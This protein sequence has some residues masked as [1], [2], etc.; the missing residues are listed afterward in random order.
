MLI[1]TESQIADT[2]IFQ[3]TMIRIVRKPTIKRQLNIS[4]APISSLKISA[5][6][7]YHDLSTAVVEDWKKTTVKSFSNFGLSH[8]T[9]AGMQC[10][11]FSNGN[12][13]N[14]TES[15]SRSSGS[16]SSDSKPLSTSK[17][18]NQDAL[19]DPAIQTEIL[20]K[21]TSLH[22][23]IMP[24]NEK[25]RGPLAK[26]SD[27]G[28]SL[29]FVFL[30]GNHSSGK[31]SFI[32]YVLGRNVQTAGVAPTDDCFTVIAPGP[33]DSGNTFY[34]WFI[35]LLIYTQCL[36]IPLFYFRSRWPSTCW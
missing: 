1:P 9:N 28:T 14:W 23:S 10:R 13:W 3:F 11:Y 33:V 7:R 26:N 32:N 31:S 29:P 6:K 24:L 20:D 21:C 19:V 12:S 16:T 2:I 27:K 25:V 35:L 18:S 34:A 8:G 5:K 17:E 15:Q 30:V 36:N 22:A 4:I